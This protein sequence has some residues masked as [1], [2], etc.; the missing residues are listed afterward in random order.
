[1][2]TTVH[3]PD[4]I[5]ERLD[6]RAAARGVSRNRVILEA[7]EAALGL[8]E[9]WAPELVAMLAEPLD[10]ATGKLLETSLAKVRRSR[11]SRRK[12]PSLG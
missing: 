11:R 2:P 1:M 12:P 3:I 9:S 6:A 7:V 5:L 10:E 4:A 8:R